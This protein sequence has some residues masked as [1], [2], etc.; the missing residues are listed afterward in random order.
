VAGVALDLHRPTRQEGVD[1]VGERELA[2]GTEG[3]DLTADLEH[4]RGSIAISW[5]VRV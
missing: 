3:I 2:T 5:G 1:R 4:G